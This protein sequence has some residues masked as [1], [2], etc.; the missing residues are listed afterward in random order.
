MEDIVTDRLILHP[1]TVE[2][3]ESLTHGELG[4][5]PHWAPSYP[6]PADAAGARRHLDTC[7]VQGDPY[8]F[9]AYEIRR[10]GDG[11]AI[12]G[13]GFHAPPDRF[14][15][16]TIG[17]GL[18]SAAQ[19][20]GYATE[21]LHALL[22]LARAHGVTEVQGDTNHHNIASQRVMTAAGM[23]LVD[24]DDRLKYYAVRWPGGTV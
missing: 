1:L 17:Y 10:R 24:Q 6:S 7:A 16:V 14:G 2:E 9:G 5:H 11:R 19:G 4:A 18:V 13:L 21:A 3:A 8:P 20:K 22:D 15:T 23:I 12:G